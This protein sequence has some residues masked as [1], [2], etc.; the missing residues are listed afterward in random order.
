VGDAALIRSAR[1]AAIAG[2][3]QRLV[4]DEALR[5]L[6]A[7]AGP[8]RAAQFD[9]RTTARLTLQALAAK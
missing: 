1:P 6:L 2:A 3:M 4:E 5:A 7:A 8:R 9:W